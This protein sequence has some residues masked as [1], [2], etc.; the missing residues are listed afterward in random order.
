MGEKEQGAA[1]ES[2]S[3]SVSERQETAG[4]ATGDPDFDLAKAGAATGDPDFDLAKASSVKSGKSNSSER[5]TGTVLSP[6]TEPI[7]GGA[8]A[9]AGIVKSKSNITNN[10]EGTTGG[11]DAAKTGPIRIDSTPARVSEGGGNDI[12]IGDPGVNGN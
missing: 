5:E 3:P 11:S 1:R 7:D 8:S 6:D 2:S 9:E 12:A 4:V 10:R